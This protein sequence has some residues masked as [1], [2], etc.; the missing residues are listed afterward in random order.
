MIFAGVAQDLTQFADRRVQAIFEIDEGVFRPEPLMERLPR[1]EPSPF[2]E[3]GKQDLKRFLLQTQLAAALAQFA[4]RWVGFKWTKAKRMAGLARR[5]AG[6]RHDGA[7]F[8]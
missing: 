7:R 8:Y 1:Y 5:L 6:T 3:Q 4:C 2:L